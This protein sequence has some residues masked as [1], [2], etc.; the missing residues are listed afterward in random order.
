ME[1]VID[2]CD[3]S[4]YCNPYLLKLT[5]PYACIDDERAKAV[6]DVDKVEMVIFFDYQNNGT[7]YVHIPKV[8]KGQFFPDM[9]LLST[10]LQKPTPMPTLPKGFDLKYLFYKQTSCTRNG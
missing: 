8:E 6:Y 10:I 1:F 9:D 4:F 5:F 3:F 7:V 2:S